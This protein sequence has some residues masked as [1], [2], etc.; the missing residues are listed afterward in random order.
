MPIIFAA[1]VSIPECNPVKLSDLYH[2]IDYLSSEFF[3]F[4]VFGLLAVVLEFF[5]FIIVF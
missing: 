5:G 3:T 2:E 1:Y 4:M